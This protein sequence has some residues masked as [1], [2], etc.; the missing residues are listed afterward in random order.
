MTNVEEP[1]VGSSFG[2]GHWTIGHFVGGMRVA[3]AR[4]PP[5]GYFFVTV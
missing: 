5:A 2:I 1:P 3:G 4:I